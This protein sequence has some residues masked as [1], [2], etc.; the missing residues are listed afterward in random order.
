MA[1]LHSNVYYKHKSPEVMKYLDKLFQ[2]V[3]GEEE[4]HKLCIAINPSNGEDLAQK[5]IDTIDDPYL[6]LAAEDFEKIEGYSVCSFVHGTMGDE[7]VG[8]IVSFLY[9]LC[10]DIH[11]QAWGCGDDDP[12]EY[13]FKFEDGSLKR[14]DDEPANDDEEDEEI[15]QTIYEWW[16]KT[17]PESIRE[18]ILNEI[19]IEDEYIVFTGKMENGNREDMEELAEEYGANVQK[20]INGKTTILVVG[21]KPGPSKLQKAKDLKVTVITETQFN[22]IVE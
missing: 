16:H 6:E 9:A 14:E 1:E 18:G 2:E 13:W 22:N 10:P 4:I 12:W 8:E 3:E 5:L 15:L 20:S 21:S 7:I 11:A 17:M 19:N